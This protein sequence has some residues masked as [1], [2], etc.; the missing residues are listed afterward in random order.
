M[1]K[2]AWPQP[3]R[4]VPYE[5]IPTGRDLLL[6][7]AGQ[8]E[9]LRRDWWTYLSALERKEDCDHDHTIDARFCA[10]EA[11]QEDCCDLNV[12]ITT[13]TRYHGVVKILPR[14]K[15]VLCVYFWNHE[16][17]PYL[18][19]DQAWFDEIATERFCL[20]ALVDAIGMRDLLR[21]QGRVTAH[22][23][24]QLRK[25]VDGLARGHKN[26]AFLSFADN[27]LIKSNWVA[28]D[29]GYETTYRPEA[30]IDLTGDVCHVIEEALGLQAY[31]VVTQ[32]ASAAEDD[33][34]LHVSDTRNHIFFGSLAAPFAELVEIDRALREALHERKHAPRELYLSAQVFWSLRRSLNGEEEHPTDPFVKYNSVLTPTDLAMYLPID[35]SHLHALLRD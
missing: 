34:L 8:L 30:F 27:I 28:T 21:R 14:S 23:L 13:S 6:V 25:G 1:D 10:I 29:A 7:G 15:V 19:V 17:R 3:S 32:G 2:L 12:C 33:S 9:A 35:R 31:A 18:V 22:Q 26:H 20:Y 16:D 4:L 11:R 24:T 5:E